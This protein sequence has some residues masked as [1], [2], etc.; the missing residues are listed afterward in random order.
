MV[1]LAACETLRHPD[2]RRTHALSLGG[3]ILAAGAGEVIGTLRPIADRDAAEI[4][5]DVHRGL[6]AGMDAADAL[7]RAQLDALASEVATGR[8]SPWRAVAVL[9]RRTHPQHT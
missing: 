3:S 9:T 7:R 4:F 5:R 8:S 1:I 6:A 2:A